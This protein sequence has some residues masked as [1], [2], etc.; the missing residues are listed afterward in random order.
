VELLAEVVFQMVGWLVE[1]CGELLL[2]LALEGIAEAMGHA[3]TPPSSRRPVRPWLAAIGYL[4]VGAAAGG[5]SLW[6]VPELFIKSPGLRLANLALTPLAS[7]AVMGA[8]GAWRA[9]H[10]KRVLRLET[11]GYGLCF[12]LPMALLRFTFGR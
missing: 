10:D 4:T 11:F 1:L 2:Q 5:L 6:L 7:G 8:I 12:A 9:R 3:F